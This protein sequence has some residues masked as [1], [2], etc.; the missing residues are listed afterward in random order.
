[1]LRMFINSNLYFRSLLA[2]VFLTLIACEDADIKEQLREPTAFHDSDECHVCG[3]VIARF[4][5][6]KSMA[7]IRKQ[8]QAI[9]FC[10]TYEMFIWL[11]QPE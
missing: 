11:L 5:G 4:Q 3:M 1:M 6:P 2:I 7:F 10:S 8:Q 9:R